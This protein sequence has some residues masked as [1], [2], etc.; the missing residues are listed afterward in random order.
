MAT[1]HSLPFEILADVFQQVNCNE[2]S[3]YGK[4]NLHQ[5]DLQ[6]CALVCRDWREASQRELFSGFAFRRSEGSSDRWLTTQGQLQYPTL[7]LSLGGNM[8]AAEGLRLLAACPQLAGLRIHQEDA[9]IQH[10]VL[11]FPRA[12]PD[13]P[14]R[15]RLRSLYLY[16]ENFST[17]LLLRILSSSQDTLSTL[18]LFAS[19]ATAGLVRTMPRLIRI[20]T[21]FAH[22]TKLILNAEPG[23]ST[24]FKILALPSITTLEA[25]A[26]VHGWA[27]EVE[28]HATPNLRTLIITRGDM[29]DFQ[30]LALGL[31]CPRLTGIRR[32]ELRG[33]KSKHR[34]DRIDGILLRTTCEELGIILHSSYHGYL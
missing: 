2:T 25:S 23:N 1:I 22:L 6:H 33:L 18:S 11:P 8:T 17:E 5:K 31:K 9:G 29:C 26:D 7:E 16:L 27:Y 14:L 21:P 19:S 30:T 15:C 34:L 10:L 28:Q 13:A 3:S 4:R 32:V 24:I 20:L 12:V